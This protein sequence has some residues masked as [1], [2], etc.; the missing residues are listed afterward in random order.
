M[1]VKQVD[2]DLWS[3]LDNAIQAYSVATQ[4]IASM[5]GWN[6]AKQ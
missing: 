1:K 3:A 5:A 6:L 2:H 4:E